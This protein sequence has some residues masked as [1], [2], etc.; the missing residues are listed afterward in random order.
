MKLSKKA[1]ISLSVAIILLIAAASLAIRSSRN[2]SVTTEQPDQTSSAEFPIASQDSS[3]QQ[4]ASPARPGSEKY[5]I[6]PS[7]TPGKTVISTPS[8]E[9]I[10][11]NDP[12]K[13]AAEKLDE[14]GY[15]LISNS[16]YDILYYKYSQGP[17]FLISL[18]SDNLIPARA[19]AETELLSKLG[20]SKEQACKLL[21]SLTIPGD[22]NEK[23]SGDDYHLSFC[24]D[25]KPLE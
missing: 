16:S 24:P 4:Q 21:V 25:G 6:S 22:V 11:T 5:R 17:S 20:I 23:L 8:G 12:E 13:V 14:K 15:L 18:H 3:F 1:I 7:G 9:K 19:A 2:K 10:E